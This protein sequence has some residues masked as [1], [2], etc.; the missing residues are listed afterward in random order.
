MLE[1][2]SWVSGQSPKINFVVQPVQYVK[3]C[4]RSE[5]VGSPRR[6]HSRALWTQTI[7]L[8]VCWFFAF[9]TLKMRGAIIK[10]LY[11]LFNVLQVE[12]SKPIS[13]LLCQSCT[14]QQKSIWITCGQNW[15]PSVVSLSLQGAFFLVF[16]FLLNDEV[17]EQST[18]LMSVGCVS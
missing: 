2:V 18:F 5:H 1:G 13:V 14:G 3:P 15:P 17:S 4:G 7:L 12:T 16:Y 11:A 9:I 10:Y 8:T 6:I